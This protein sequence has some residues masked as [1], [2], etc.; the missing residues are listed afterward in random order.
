M[1]SGQEIV[2]QE[3]CKI[4]LAEFFESIKCIDYKKPKA[5]DSYYTAINMIL[6]NAETA[7]YD[8]L[9]KTLSTINFS[10]RPL[11]IAPNTSYNYLFEAEVPEGVTGLEV[12]ML[13]EEYKKIRI[14]PLHYIEDCNSFPEYNYDINI[15]KPIP[16]PPFNFP[17]L[18]FPPPS[19]LD[20]S[21]IRSFC[22]E[23][24]NSV[25]II[26]IGKFSGIKNNRAYLV[27]DTYYGPI[28]FELSLD[29]TLVDLNSYTLVP[30]IEKVKSFELDGNGEYKM[31]EKEVPG[32]IL[33]FNNTADTIKTYGALNWEAMI[34]PCGRQ[35]YEYKQFSFCY[36]DLTGAIKVTYETDST[37]I[38]KPDDQGWYDLG[39]VKIRPK[40]D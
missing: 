36:D 26:F 11:N 1:Y 25:K 38:I 14:M 18:N 23:P 17:P 10:V 19:S 34:G 8:P 40:D 2:A 5:N 35:P 28:N 30:T 6:I 32:G 33:T 22:I 3:E 9:T 13:A 7:Y 24:D 20:S 39:T 12:I 16:L 37:E 4:V 21:Y 27:G 29:D 31:V 15:P